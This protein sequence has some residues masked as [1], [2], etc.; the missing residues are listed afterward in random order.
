MDSSGRVLLI[1]PSDSRRDVLV[2]RL[3]AQGHAIEE[4]ADAATGADMA[5]SSPP[6]AV[7]ADLWMP[8]ISGVQLCRLLKSEPA[9]AEVPIILCGDHDEPRNRFWAERAGA[10]A[11]VIK[12]RTGELVRAL[13]KAVDAP[14]R[15]EGFFV[16]LS[17]G[18]VD[19]RDRL[20]RHLDT[21]LFESVIAGELRSLASAAGFERL[22][23][24]LAQLMSQITRYRWI[25]LATQAPER[26]AI[27]H[28]PAL[29]S[30]AE[31]EARAVL[32]A[33]PLLTVEDEDAVN[34]ER[35]PGA[36]VHPVL[37]SRSPV[38]R[39]AFGPCAEHEQDAVLLA[40]LVARELGG[41][42]KIATLV[43]ESQRLAASDP[44][45]GLLNRRAF[46]SVMN[47]ELARCARHGYPLSLALLD[48]DHF[49]QV[50]DKRGHATGDA[51]LA[52]IGELLRHHPRRS[53]MASRWG[54][55]EFVVAYTSTS[56][57]GAHL[58]TERLR[59]AIEERVI[60]DAAGDRVPVTASIGVASWHAGESL[61]SLVDRA[62]RA[63][64][65]SKTAGRNRVSVCV[66]D[67]SAGL[68]ASVA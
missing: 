40:P 27:H 1:D 10:A 21:A 22:F 52:S 4:T 34:A 13:A 67:V 59:R 17:G 33:G 68:L 6:A 45:T 49:K 30:I 28:H 41:A 38:A 60:L 31:A 57:A 9:T 8:G 66:E 11:Y 16:Q 46:S 48:V 29:R 2:R 63:M 65:A 14:P 20:A 53:D 61:E 36:V 35:G 39:F 32:G 18:S 7:V 54:G 3:R 64:Y 26:I 12:G 15:D 55:E 62:D 43:E 42:I 51:V 19:I 50:N 25:A 47:G 24:R 37:F 58:A 5:L 56:L 44:L 23:D